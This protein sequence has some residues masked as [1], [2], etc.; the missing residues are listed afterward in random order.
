MFGRE[1]ARVEIGCDLRCVSAG[2]GEAH[3]AI[4]TD[5]IGRVVT[6]ADATG[7]VTIRKN[8][9]RNTALP[10]ESVQGR[11]GFAID[12]DLP[13]NGLER[14]E[15]IVPVA[16]ANPW[17]AV[18]S[19]D[20]TGDAAAQAA[21]PIANGSLGDGAEEKTARGGRREEQRGKEGRQFETSEACERA[22]AGDLS[23]G[24]IGGCDEAAR[25]G[26]AFLFVGVEDSGIGATKDC[27]E[28]PCEVD[29]IADA[30]VHALPADGAM[31]VGGVAEEKDSAGAKV[32]C[33]AMVDAIGRE[34][35]DAFD[36]RVEVAKDVFADVVPGEVGGAVGIFAHGSDETGTVVAFERE[37]DEEVI[38]I[39]CYVEFVIQ[40]GAGAF[41]VG[42]VEHVGVGAAG[43]SDA[44]VF[45][46]GGARTIAAGEPGR[47]AEFFCAIGFEKFGTHGVAVA[48]EAEELGLALDCDSPCGEM[49]N[50]VLLVFVLRIDQ[51]IWKRTEALADGA[52]V[53]AGDAAAVAPDVCG[54]RGAALGDDFVG[55]ADLGVELEGA[56]LNGHGARSGSR[57]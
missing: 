18:A 20:V 7:F 36:G 5:E 12:M 13:V 33:D 17:Q 6:Q 22:G 45:A 32:F 10:A 51:R 55:D 21:G 57:G 3:V 52:E 11:L 34:P 4:G 23:E 49:L 56:R 16:E 39:E 47:G 14:R 19:P 44:E 31:D 9:Q 37:D 26:D 53:E 38:A 41:D 54:L 25:E 40:D 15:V 46:D 24:A 42:D 1:R 27:R 35:V 30:G 28:F 2:F 8:M 43:K 29:G 48:F 50:Q